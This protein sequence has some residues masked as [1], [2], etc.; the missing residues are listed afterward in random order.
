MIT[1]IAEGLRN[2]DLSIKRVTKLVQNMV[3]DE[4]ERLREENETM[5]KFLKERSNDSENGIT[6]SESADKCRKFLEE[7]EKES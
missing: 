5:K 3:A 6:R 2:A 4:I 1:D 7:L